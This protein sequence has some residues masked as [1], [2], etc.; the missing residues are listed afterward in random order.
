VIQGCHVEKMGKLY[1]HPKKDI[2]QHLQQTRSAKGQKK[3]ER[4][5]T[6]FANGSIEKKKRVWARTP[7]LSG[8]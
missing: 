2:K 8:A 5:G 6:C 1:S 7:R 4:G 3:R